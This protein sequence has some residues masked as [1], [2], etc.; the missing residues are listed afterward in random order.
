M[1]IAPF[2][3]EGQDRVTN[4]DEHLEVI[5]SISQEYEL[6]LLDYTQDSLSYTQDYPYFVNEEK[7]V[8]L[9]K[10]IKKIANLTPKETELLSTQLRTI[11][12]NRYSV[13]EIEK[14][15]ASAILK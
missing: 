1:V 10:L 4:K 14:A 5:S 6:P 3:I 11:Y 13:S 12:K 2:Y 9:S 15:Y 8:T 7:E